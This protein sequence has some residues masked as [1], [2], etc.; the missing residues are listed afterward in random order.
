MIFLGERGMVKNNTALEHHE[1]DFS[2]KFCRDFEGEKIVPD[3]WM[4]G[5]TNQNQQ[6]RFFAFG[7]T[8]LIISV[9]NVIL[10]INFIFCKKNGKKHFWL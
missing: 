3:G 1:V 7:S 5:R 6:T 4:D 2:S 10:E 8:S 9:S